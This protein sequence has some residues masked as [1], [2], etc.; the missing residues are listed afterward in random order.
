[1]AR[2]HVQMLQIQVPF[3]VK[4]SLACREALRPPWMYP[5]GSMM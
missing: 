1:M 5:K 2:A 4:P 3:L